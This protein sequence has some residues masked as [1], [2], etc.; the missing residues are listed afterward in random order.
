MC[1]QVN[2][3]QPFA[4]SLRFVIT[5]GDPDSACHDMRPDIAAYR[6]VCLPNCTTDFGMMDMW[7]EVKPKNSDP[8]RDP[9]P[10]GPSMAPADGVRPPFHRSS[11]KAR[12]TQG[13]LVA[14]ANAVFCRQFR[15]RLFSV[16]ICGRH[17]RIILWDKS[18]AIVTEKFDIISQPGHLAQFFWRYNLLPL[19]TRGYDPSVTTP[20]AHEQVLAKRALRITAANATLVKLCVPND[21]GVV[22]DKFYVAETPRFIPRSSIGRS[23]RGFV[24]YDLAKRR[25]VWIK[26]YWRVIGPGMEK[27]GDIYMELHRHR[28]PHIPRF[29]RAGDIKSS[30]LCTTSNNRWIHENWA[31]RTKELRTYSLYRVVLDEVGRDLTSFESSWEYTNAITD[32]LEGIEPFSYHSAIA[33][34]SAAHSV[35]YQKANILHRDISVGNVLITHDGN[36]GLLIDWELSKRVPSS[37]PLAPDQNMNA[38]APST[39]NLDLTQRPPHEKQRAIRQPDR[40]ASP[41][42]FFQV[43]S[44][45]Y[46]AGHMAVYLCT[47]AYAPRSR[48]PPAG[49][50]GVVLLGA[51]MGL[52][53]I[54]H[55]QSN[56]RETWRPPLRF[57]PSISGVQ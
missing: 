36:H 11:M 33:D 40:T 8:F 7:I 24:A 51:A 49:R 43:S 47:L 37:T 26:D 13:Q 31:C 46:C 45:T 28:V 42:P 23:T 19:N 4:P 17:A 32:A 48:A 10:G 55:S 12:D 56:T 16:L 18:C 27:E 6:T 14:Y 5:S 25:I 50:S 1:L 41:Y 54:Y 35:A 20:D 38:S 44:L 57:R 2:A 34:R 39:S 53:K 30:P 21:T 9:A 52:L 29:D 3:L 15:T 22:G